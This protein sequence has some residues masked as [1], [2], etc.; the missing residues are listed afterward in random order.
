MVKGGKRGRKVVKRGWKGVVMSDVLK[1]CFEEVR[2]C[3]RTRLLLH[4]PLPSL[5]SSNSLA[6]LIRSTIK[7]HSGSVMTAKL[8]N[9]KSLRSKGSLI[10]TFSEMFEKNFV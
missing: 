5:V 6:S 1:M 2:S 8:K 7:C 3:V 4:E 9:L 10:S